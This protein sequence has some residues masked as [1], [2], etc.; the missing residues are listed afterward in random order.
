MDIDLCNP[1]PCSNGAACINTQ[2]DYYCHCP[3]R[4]AGKNCSETRPACTTLPC[5]GKSFR[6][7]HSILIYIFRDNIFNQRSDFKIVYLIC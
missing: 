5:E 3:D 6:L 2:G 4:W 1:N 7:K